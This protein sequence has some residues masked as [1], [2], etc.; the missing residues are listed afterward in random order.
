MALR[1]GNRPRNRRVRRSTAAD[2]VLEVTTKSSSAKRR[3]RR[4]M[5]GWV[6][7]IVLLVLLGVGA[8]VG[9]RE[10]FQR[11]FFSNPDY[12][13]T[14]VNL[15]LD[16]VLTREEALA[17]TG[18]REGENIFSVDLARVEAALRAIPMVKNVSIERE[19]PGTISVTLVSRDPVAW[20]AP[21]GEQAGF[22]PGA[23]SLMVDMDGVLMNARRVQPEFFHLPVIYGVQ[24]DN[25]RAGEPLHSDDLRNALQLLRAVSNRPD[26]LLK[27]RSIDISRGWAMEVVSDQNA[28]ILL[29]P[30]DLDDQLDRLQ[31][32]LL[33]CV[34]SGRSLESVNLVVKRNTPVKFAMAAAPSP[35]PSPE[36]SPAK[37]RK[38]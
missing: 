25:L 23:G 5:V 3:R 20:V 33:H 8:Y 13:L 31:K 10:V 9:M 14:R 26:S 34:E 12:T 6:L 35:E 37:P 11:F 27:I 17:E 4:A 1:S 32:L 16:G 30:A 22:S 18:L 2:Y 7:R 36:P 15:E 21:E 29:A 28:K 19:L 24:G 38:R